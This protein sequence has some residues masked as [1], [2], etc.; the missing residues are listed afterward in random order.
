MPEGRWA[1][2]YDVVTSGWY[3][4]RVAIL[5]DAAHAM[6]PNLGQAACVAMMNGVALAQA[7]DVY[8]IDAALAAWQASEKPVADRVQRYSRLYGTIGTHW[9]TR[10]L[11]VRS[12][13]VW[14][15][16]KAKPAQRRIQFAAGYFPSLDSGAAPST[17][18]A[19]GNGSAADLTGALPS[20]EAVG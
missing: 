9:P 4:G 1:P 17:S 14:S 18:G 5:G 7:L 10:M 13:L 12:A 11:G 3:R 2:F 20:E 6:S 8:G 16:A 19:A 15:L